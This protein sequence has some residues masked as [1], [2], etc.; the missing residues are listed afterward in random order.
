M[1]STSDAVIAAV[2]VVVFGPL[3]I[4]LLVLLF[5]TCCSCWQKKKQAAQKAKKARLDEIKKMEEGKNLP[6]REVETLWFMHEGRL[7]DPAVLLEGED[8]KRA[9][10][11]RGFLEKQKIG[12]QKKAFYFELL[13]P[14]VVEHVAC[15][16]EGKAQPS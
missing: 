13:P 4:M 12:W 9:G 15:F 5:A 8:T 2:V 11:L 14:E 6:R 16:V 10:K 7:R 3:A 1:D